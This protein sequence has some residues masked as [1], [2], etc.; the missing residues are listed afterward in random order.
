MKPPRCPGFGRLLGSLVHVRWS[1][2]RDC[3]SYSYR[4]RH[5]RIRRNPPAAPARV[6]TEG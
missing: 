5:P 1:R 4:A 3:D 2:C 6:R